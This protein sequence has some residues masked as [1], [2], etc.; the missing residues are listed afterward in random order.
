MLDQLVPT[1]SMIHRHCHHRHIIIIIISRHYDSFPP[2]TP[3]WLDTG[4]DYAV[5][6]ADDSEKVRAAFVRFISDLVLISG[7]LRDLT[8]EG[9]FRLESPRVSHG[10]HKTRASDI[11]LYMSM[12]GSK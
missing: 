9:F 5:S 11:Y 2:R 6:E 1:A 8:R 3:A 12:V 4:I 7:E 10:Y